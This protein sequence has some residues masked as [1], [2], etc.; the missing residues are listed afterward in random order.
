MHMPLQVA[1][2]QILKCCM[3]W[4]SQSSTN[5]IIIGASRSEPHRY[6]SYEKIDVPM[7]VYM[8]VAIRRPRVHHAQCSAVLYSVSL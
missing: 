8:Y 6:H 4:S 7:Y 1:P 3:N 5:V 2:C